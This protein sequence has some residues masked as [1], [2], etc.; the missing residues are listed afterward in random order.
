MNAQE[1][2]ARLVTFPSVV[3]TPDEAFV[4]RVRG[5]C[6]A[7]GAEIAIIPGPEGDRSNLVVRVVRREVGTALFSDKRMSRRR[8][9]PKGAEPPRA[10]E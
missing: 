10:K 9:S 3:D 4:D 7:A 1:I 8:A 2:L 5:D 6:Q